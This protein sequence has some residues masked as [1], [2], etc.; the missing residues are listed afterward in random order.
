MD[1]KTRQF[2]KALY[3]T[4]V[5]ESV[6]S[7]QE[8]FNKM[9]MHPD[10]DDYSSQVVTLFRSLSKDDQK[11]FMKII[12]QT[13]IDDVSHVCGII[14]GTSTLTN[15]KIEPTLLLDSKETDEFVQDMFLAHIEEEDL[16]P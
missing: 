15:C 6:Q 16:Y 1:G 3:E 5:T 12:E 10:M 7:Y 8:M 11:I 14:D 9:E 2:A 13:I 4:V